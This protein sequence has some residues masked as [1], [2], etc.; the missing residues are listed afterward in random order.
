MHVFDSTSNTFRGS[1]ML[2]DVVKFPIPAHKFPYAGFDGGIGL[3]ADFPGQVIHVG[4]GG[5]DVAF[6]HGE[7][8]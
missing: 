1:R 7:I 8:L 4:T 3:E 2:L 5:G 6:L